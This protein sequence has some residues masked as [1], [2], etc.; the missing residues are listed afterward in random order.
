MIPSLS[1]VQTVP[2]FLKKE[3]PAL[4]S[5]PMPYV[6][7]FQPF[8]KPFE[9]DRHLGQR[10]V[11]VG[12]HPVDQAAADQG[13]AHGRPARPMGAVLK[14]IPD[15]Y[16]KVVVGVH[17]ARAGADD[18]VAVAVRIVA[19]GD[20]VAVFQ[21]DQSG[22]GVGGRTVHPD[23]SVFVHGHKRKSRI[24]HRIDQINFQSVFLGDGFPVGHGRP[25]QGIHPDPQSGGA[26]AFP[27]RLYSS[28]LPRKGLMKSYSRIHVPLK[29]HANKGLRFTSRLR[30]SQQFIG[31]VFNPAGDD[32]SRPGPRGADCT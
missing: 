3:A 5:S 31:P 25:A 12:G 8:D 16:R 13:L 18:A 1:V 30:L 11:Q 28:G 6:P 29:G 7:V 22:H 14:E 15:G 21:L 17:Q 19:E 4:S 9:T 26:D 10:P 20:I 2:S 32:R 23:F 24:Y 27:D